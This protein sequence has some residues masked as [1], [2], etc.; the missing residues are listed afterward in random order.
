MVAIIHDQE[1]DVTNQ[2]AVASN[3]GV[4]HELRND[5]F[6]STPQ[7]NGTEHHGKATGIAIL[8]SI[9]CKTSPANFGTSTKSTSRTC[10]TCSSTA[11]AS[12]PPE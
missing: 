1:T 9:G 12:S 11:T 7:M 8:P 4:V 3:S 6:I 5:A 10:Q 2:D